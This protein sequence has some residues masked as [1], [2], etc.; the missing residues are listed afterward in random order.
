M[1]LGDSTL[2]IGSHVRVTVCPS[3]ANKDDNEY[4]SHTGRTG[5]LTNIEGPHGPFS[6]TLDTPAED[7]ATDYC[8]ALEVKL[9]KEVDRAGN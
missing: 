2:H 7:G 4:L 5:I 8:V 1:Q 3:D 9:M 6:V